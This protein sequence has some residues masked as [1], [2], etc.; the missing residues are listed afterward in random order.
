MAALFKPTRPH[1]LPS[2]AEI[3]EKDGRLHVCLRERG[4]AVLYP[5]T[6][7][8]KR[9]LKPAAK[10]AAEVTFADGKRRRVRF[11]PNRDAAAV[12][13]ADLLKKIENEK[14]GVRDQYAD[15]RTS[16]LADTLKEYE[17]HVLDKGATA[18]EATQ[19]ARRCEIV[20][21]A[22]GFV[23]LRDL[24]ATAPERWLADRRRLP[25]KDGGFGPATSNHYRKSL[26]AFGNWLVKARRSAESPFRHIPKVN[27]EVDVRHRRRPLSAEEFTRLIEAARAG[28][29]FR[30]LAG[31]DRAALYT[32][33][34][35]TGL[36]AKGL[37]SLSPRSFALDADPPVVVVEA[38]YSKHRRRDEVPLHPELVGELRAWLAD[39]PPGESLGSGNWA[40]HTSAVDLIKRDLEVA[41]AA[42]IAEAQ[43]PKEEGA[44][45]GVRLPHRPRPRRA[46]R[47]LPLASTHVRHQPG[48]RRRGTERRERTRSPFHHHVDDGPV[49]PRGHPRHRRSGRQVESSLGAPV[50]HR[51]A[52]DAGDRHA[53][54]VRFGSST[55][56]STRR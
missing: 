15:H 56:S 54:G 31:P 37:A 8:G 26:V 22:V 12:M 7:D 41:R 4:K 11:S 21:E 47:R 30:G 2:G 25:K 36:R 13:L 51:G 29:A 28:G 48:E 45:R 55:G 44:T 6:A 35:M 1:P 43:T 16:P 27:A 53:R 3:V 39:K 46:G 50:G 10:W 42:W 19:A 38:A 20:F 5:L 9:Y 18:K 23:T 49:H 34:G 17:R 14:A 40:K 52:G 32:V 24:D 33:A